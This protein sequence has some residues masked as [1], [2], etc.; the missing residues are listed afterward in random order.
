[1]ATIPLDIAEKLIAEAQ[2]TVGDKPIAVA[3]VDSG[4]D[5]I[6]F[7]KMDKTRKTM[8]RVAIAKAYTAAISGRETTEIA[9]K[10]RENPVFWQSVAMK[11]PGPFVFARGGAPLIYNDEVVGAVGI[12]GPSG[13]IDVACA[14][15]AAA[16]FSRIFAGS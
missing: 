8:G 15:A 3:V 9:Q 11:D 16:L 10:A 14:R 4:G 6:A 13:D 5:L 12:S 7:Q 1:M 2:K